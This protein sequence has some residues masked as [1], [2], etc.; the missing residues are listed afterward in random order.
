MRGALAGVPALLA[1]GLLLAPGP[2]AGQA[3]CGAST[4][5]SISP[6]VMQ[7]TDGSRAPGLGFALEG[8]RAGHDLRTAFARSRYLEGSLRGR[9]PFRKLR[10]PRGFS[11]AV[12]GGLSVSLSDR[13]DPDPGA[14]V[15]ADLH[16]FNFGYLGVGGRASFELASDLEESAFAAGGDL[17]WVDPTRPLLPSVV[18]LAEWVRPTRSQRRD[19]LDLPNAGHARFEARG[20]WLM[21]MAA[22]FWL[23]VDAGA[24]ADRGLDEA[25]EAM[26]LDRGRYLALWFGHDGAWRAGR[27]V[28]ESIF[29]GHERGRRPSPGEEGR[30]W[31]VGID[32]GLAPPRP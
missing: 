14:P 9:V 18:L 3:A 19:D 25:L 26:G 4:A 15:E 2:G 13:T 27:I 12:M 11:A 20:Y 31:T 22:G 17:R 32:L 30:A 29:A 23:E 1:S 8:C 6:V 16:A 24:Y 28:V 21:R 5:V 7:D 10:L